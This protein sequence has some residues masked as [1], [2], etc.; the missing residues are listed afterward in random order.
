MTPKKA[1]SWSGE[2]W[3]LVRQQHGVIARGQLLALGLGS[4]AIEHRIGAG[5]LHRIW[6]GV[7]AVGRPEVSRHGRL[8]AALLSCGPTARASHGSAG[9]LWGIG[10]WQRG[11]DV[12]VPN[13]V[14]R[15]RPGIRLHRRLGLDAEVSCQVSGMP[16]TSPTDTLVDMASDLPDAGLE[17][18]IR[19]A[20]RLGLADPEELRAALGSISP[21]PGVGRL[22][23]VLASETFSLTDS[24]LERQFLRLVRAAALPPPKTQVWL[25]GYRV[26]FYWPELGLVVETDGLRYHRTP[27][28]QRRD[29]VRDQVHTAAGLTA[30]RFTAAQVRFE[31]RQTIA[32]LAAVI[33]RLQSAR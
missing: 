25:N 28:Q 7:Y 11:I 5:R 33:S 27:S 29:R 23:A 31:P 26:D 21:R 4:E 8:M 19:E 2:V 18:A 14:M 6:R 1:Q 15:R 12:V 16:V 24:E 32:T 13:R 3:E 22:R 9:W 10:P 30:L 20:D 17:R